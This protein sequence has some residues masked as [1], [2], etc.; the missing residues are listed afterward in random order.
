MALLTVE[1]TYKDGRVELTERPNGIGGDG[2]SSCNLSGLDES[3][4]KPPT[5][6]T[7]DR[8]TLRQ[9]AFARMKEGIHL[10]DHLTPSER[11]FM[12]ALTSSLA[13]VDT[14]VV[15]YAYD[16]DEP[17]KHQI[18]REVLEDL[19][20]EGRLIFSTQVFNEFSSVMMRPKRKR[21]LTPDEIVVILHEL[22]ATGEVVLIA[23]SMTFRA[24]DAM[25]RHGLSSG[26][27]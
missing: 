1:G 12:I 13:L 10:G 19:S 14:N 4:A 26:M 20:N 11:S 25:P 24:L 9:R 15:V 21:P 2:S 6:A 5:E 22:E 7:E 3:G 27:R 23:P 17:S 8:E 18:A 16:S